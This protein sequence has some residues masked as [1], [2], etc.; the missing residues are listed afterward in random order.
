MPTYMQ[1]WDWWFDQAW[2]Q[3]LRF[4]F[5][6]LDR[7]IVSN[8][9]LIPWKTWR[10]CSC[11]F[12]YARLN[13]CK[14]SWQRSEANVL[15]R[16]A[17]KL[18]IFKMRLRRTRWQLRKRARSEVQDV[19][20][21]AKFAGRHRCW[22]ETP[23]HLPPIFSERPRLNS[24]RPPHVEQ[25]KVSL[26]LDLSRALCVSLRRRCRL[27]KGI[28]DDLVNWTSRVSYRNRDRRIVMKFHHV[29]DQIARTY[30]QDK[31]TRNEPNQLKWEKTRL[32]E[33]E[34]LF[35]FAGWEE[36]KR[37]MLGAHLSMSTSES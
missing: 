29:N 4:V 20:A 22:K 19:S 28:Q 1:G 24:Y 6:C 3:E 2:C 35:N 17:D 26:N 8:S 36:C 11:A 7:G 30:N 12:L 32:Y 5:S 9:W 16:V 18:L 15:T 37:M 27:N 33:W 31:T 34:R 21:A 14:R 23:N 13:R 10:L 25:S